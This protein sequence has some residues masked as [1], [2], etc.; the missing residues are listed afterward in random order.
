MTLTI[1][2]VAKAAG[3]NVETVRYYE[4]RGLLTPSS[5]TDSGY[6]QYSDDDLWRLAFI[7]RA[8]QFGFTLAEIADLLEEASP[9][10]IGHRAEEK[11]KAVEAEIENLALVRERLRALMSVC[12]GDADGNCTALDINVGIDPGGST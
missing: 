1:G 7:R 6:R 12:G 5:R 2:Q 4:R 8:Q 10:A 3:V 11:L 9:Q